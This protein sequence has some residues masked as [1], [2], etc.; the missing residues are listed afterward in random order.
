[1]INAGIFAENDRVQLLEGIL[2]TKMAMSAQHATSASLI[3]Q[4]L[5]KLLPGKWHIGIQQPVT[6]ISSEPE[7][8][9]AIIQGEIRDYS[10]HHPSGSDVGLVIEVA[11]T[12]LQMDREQKL[13]IYSRAGI[14][15]YWIINLNENNVEVYSDPQHDK[16]EYASKKIVT[17][18]LSIT[19]EGQ[20]LGGLK[21]SDI[22]P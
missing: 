15:E 7:P 11:D 5:A 3:N 1:M 8:D 4:S 9:L 12:S 10:Q 20:P 22:L 2:L 19:L 18:S 6:M 21:V 14:A 13:P 16:A 17:D